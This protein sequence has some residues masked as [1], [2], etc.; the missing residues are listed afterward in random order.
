MYSLERTADGKYIL[1]ALSD[2]TY[3]HDRRLTLTIPDPDSHAPHS[4]IDPTSCENW[5]E[6]IPL[7][8]PGMM[9][10]VIDGQEEKVWEFCDI[11]SSTMG[12]KL[13]LFFPEGMTYDLLPPTPVDAVV[14]SGIGSQE[15]VCSF[16]D[17]NRDADGSGN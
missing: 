10:P 16:E 13:T 1:E 12:D 7:F 3:G 15:I 8:F 14:C 11:S 9:E 2:Q 17:Q 5:R 4:P 6:Q